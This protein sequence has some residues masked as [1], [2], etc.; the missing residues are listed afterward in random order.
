MRGKS[1]KRTDIQA[2]RA[3]AVLAVVIYHIWPERLVGGFMGVD[4]FFVIS[5]YLMTLT[6]MRDATPVLIAKDRVK[7]TWSYL[8]NFYARRIKRLIPAASV[9]LLGTLAMVV[10][11]GNY[12]TIIETTK[13]IFSSALFFQN[14]QLA[15]DSVDYLA[16][17]NPPTA[18]QHFWSLSLEEQFY[19]VW[20]L[21]LLVILFCTI[22]LSIL[23]KKSKTMGAIIPTSILVAGFFIYGYYMTKTDP[24]A[25]YFVTYARVWEL[26]LGGAIA[27]LPSLKSHDLKLLLPWL[28]TAMYTYA[29][30]SWGGEGF[31]GWHALVPVIGTALVIYGGTGTSESKLS[32]GNLFKAR[33]IQWVG[34]VSYSLYLWHW[35]LIILMPMLLGIYIDGSNGPQLKLAILVLSFIAAGLSFKFIEIPAQKIQ[36]KKRYTYLLFA[37]I[38]GGVA[39]LAL[40]TKNHTETKVESEVNALHKVVLSNTDESECMGAKWQT[41]QDT[42]GNGFGVINPRFQQ[43]TYV[44]SYKK[45][46]DGKKCSFYHP[47]KKEQSKDPSVHCIVGNPSSDYQVVVYGD[48]HTSHWTNAFNEL[49]K[50]NN[51]RFVVMDSRR[52]GSAEISQPQ[53]KNRVEY[54]KKSKILD[55]SKYVIL[56][57]I[58]K[59][60]DT[61]YDKFGN[62]GVLIETIKSVT[63]TPVYLL[64]DT[65]PASKLFGAECLIYNTPCRREANAAMKSINEVNNN[66]VAAE[67]IDKDHIIPTH[68]MFCDD[69]YCYS[70]IG[71]LSVYYNLGKRK[72]ITNSHMTGSFSSTLS[73]PLGQRL[74]E[75]GII[76]N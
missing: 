32:F 52:C 50:R 64:E 60:D 39:G 22:N 71:G 69:K 1:Q 28:G 43:F 29:I 3:I 20:P 14:W 36:I 34:D 23:Y 46:L 41:K 30:F 51:I 74:K 15:E 21:L 33:P 59:S 16:A 58:H 8:V 18:V 44:D 24:S 17:T 62:I 19:F 42:C 6:L 70:S 53:C 31:P 37:V 66:L 9:T 68:D 45:V 47:R 4:I 11:T 10:A 72:H 27:F 40:F 5:G 48:S 2:L 26:L 54:L 56:S 7:A 67:I 65:P 63:T 73:W 57:S 55:E 38:V 49:G 76:P 12:T 35:P 13:Q 25:A 61:F 75:Y